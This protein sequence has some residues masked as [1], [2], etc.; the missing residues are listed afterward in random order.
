V[1]EQENSNEG[2]EGG[3]QEPELLDGSNEKPEKAGNEDGEAAGALTTE[4]IEDVAGDAEH[5]VLKKGASE[6]SEKQKV[7]KIKF[8]RPEKEEGESEGGESEEEQVERA[9]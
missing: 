8:L 9:M 6:N 4:D 1:T 3:E 7:T 5:D 2:D